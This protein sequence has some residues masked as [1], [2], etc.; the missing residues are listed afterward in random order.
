M[1]V[2]S[3]LGDLFLTVPEVEHEIARALFAGHTLADEFL[4]DAQLAA[5]MRA[6]DVEP[7]EGEFNEAVDFLQRHEH[8]DL[9]AVG[10]EIRIQQGPAVAAMN[11]PFGHFFAAF[12]AWSAGPRRHIFILFMRSVLAQRSRTIAYRMTE[13]QDH[14]KPGRRVP[15]VLAPKQAIGDQLHG[16]LIYVCDPGGYNDAD[17]ARAS[18]E[19]RVHRPTEFLIDNDRV[20]GGQ[21]RQ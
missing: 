6:L 17:V 18:I 5:A 2:D 10:L 1:D 4:V 11:D 3:I 12:R 9:D 7:A 16:N 8:R 14:F 13:P 20:P 19:G 21:G 15:D